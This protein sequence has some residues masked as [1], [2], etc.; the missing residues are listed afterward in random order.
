MSVQ[1]VF[2]LMLENRAFDHMLGFSMI[3]GRDA[4]TG[5]PT[6][7]SGL[8]G[9]ES[10]VFNGSTYSV[11]KGADMVMPVDPGH[12][13]TN[14][15]EQL[16]GSA[17][18]YPPGGA[19][20]AIDKSGFVASYAASGG[21]AAPGE[22]LKC[23][24][25]E[26]L[27]VLAALAQEFAVCDNWHA[28]MPG[29]TWPN[30]MFVHA[31]SAGGLDHSPTNQE[32]VAWETIGGFQ[33]KAGGIFDALKK[34]GVSY[35]LY[36][37]DDFPMVAALKGIS[38][39]DIHHYSEFVGDLSQGTFPYSYVFIEPSYDVLNE[40]RNSTSQHPLTDITL[41]EALIKETYEA[42][43][44]SALWETSVLIVTWDEHGGFYDHVTPPAAVA[45]GDSQPKSKYNQYGFTFEQYGP[46][47]PAIV[48]SPLIPK[49]TIDHRLYDH[50]SVPAM[51]KAVFGAGPLT[52]R[53]GHANSPDQLLSLQTARQ[54][55][56]AALP[57]P[58][59]AA[60][61][62]VMSMAVRD[63]STVVASRPDETV[64]QGTLPVIINSA[65]R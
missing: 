54:D 9:R 3:N 42:L 20:P 17:A 65:L 12:E 38:L 16:C 14:V 50:A 60:A 7:V 11:T 35:R 32:I 21:S 29:P 24:A 33:F 5:Q 53:D 10:N 59:A 31:A 41:G 2:V 4:Q 30:R 18:S 48:I 45:P 37:G 55:T 28:S 15:L 51:I 8:T 62:P 64:N 49:N 27:P 56:P 58:A 6:Q 1:H 22:V 43:R 13:F 52:A 47:V 57:S 26:Q 63:L 34:K 36:A 23:F 25:P 39:F 40:Y 46:R 19:Y 44:N 61:Q